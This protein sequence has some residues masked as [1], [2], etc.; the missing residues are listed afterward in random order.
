MKTPKTSMLM[1]ALVICF[2]AAVYAQSIVPPPA[3]PG[4][5]VAHAAPAAPNV[6]PPAGVTSANPA[7]AAVAAPTP[8]PQQNL[9]DIALP[10]APKPPVADLKPS[11]PGGAQKASTRKASIK[12]DGAVEKAASVKQE[13]VDPFSGLAG[14]PVSDSQLN[15]F[16]FPEAVE[17]IYFSEGAPLPECA[18]DAPATDPCKPVFL[19]GKKMMLLQL[20]AG[21]K[22]P[23]QM[24]VHMESGRVVTL[25]LTPTAGPGAVIRVEGA[26]DGASDTRLAAGAKANA[27]GNVTPSASASE[28]SVAML[29]QF[30]AGDIPAGFEP[31]AVGTSV[32][33]E[34]FDVIPQATWDNGANLRAHLYTVQAHDDQP[35]LIDASLFRNENVRA[36]ALDRDTITHSAPAQL[37][38]LEY[39]NTEN[40]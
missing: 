12:P 9:I 33:F 15:R 31:V 22:G 1:A 37:Y 13:P 35:V 8:P 39:V 20:R 4:A 3:Q 24:L 26:E 19:N 23:V 7:V 36:L 10:A 32:R 30:A 29:A 25:N 40:Q 17:G 38:L 6:A 2:P 16:V 34:H 11:A 21:A 14:T 5:P 28:K 27:A 18:K